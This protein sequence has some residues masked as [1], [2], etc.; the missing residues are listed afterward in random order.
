[1]DIFKCINNRAQTKQN[2]VSKGNNKKKYV[3]PNDNDDGGDNDIQCSFRPIVQNLEKMKGQIPMNLHTNSNRLFMTETENK[4][5]S[6]ENLEGRRL[7]ASLGTPVCQEASSV[8]KRICET[9]QG[10]PAVL[11]EPSNVTVKRMREALDTAPFKRS[12]Q[13]VL[14]RV[15]NPTSSGSGA[16]VSGTVVAGSYSKPTHKPPAHSRKFLT[17]RSSQ[18]PSREKQDMLL[19]VIKVTSICNEAGKHIN[20]FSRR[21]NN[22]PSSFWTP[23]VVV[24]G[25]TRAF[26]KSNKL[27]NPTLGEKDLIK[28]ATFVKLPPTS[29]KCSDS[30]ALKKKAIVGERD[31]YLPTLHDCFKKVTLPNVLQ[32]SSKTVCVQYVR[33]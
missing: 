5:V 12:I 24:S 23:K 14:P 7:L 28:K 9:A 20:N 22:K 32:S 6:K 18:G 4:P 3:M 1:M 31:Q 29:D 25:Q 11:S 13:V 2:S 17:F 10:I 15:S 27:N 26:Q 19:P 21:L 30:F 8:S 33:R 16:P